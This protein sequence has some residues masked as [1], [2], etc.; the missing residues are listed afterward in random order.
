MCCICTYT[1]SV[2]RVWHSKVYI[3]YVTG[4][5]LFVFFLQTEHL[6]VR[7]GQL[8]LDATK[9]YD[10]KVSYISTF[11]SLSDHL[12][13][14]QLISFT[15]NIGTHTTSNLFRYVV[16]YSFTNN[17]LR[18]LDRKFNKIIF[19]VAWRSRKRVK[20][21]FLK[22]RSKRNSQRL[23]MTRVLMYLT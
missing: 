2:N 15:W 5:F 17:I 11:S 12:T 8:E 13:L 3:V 9:K 16:E 1:K 20:S 23:N 14:S 10:Y 6:I 19:R 4:K 22:I 7:T 21:D 18:L